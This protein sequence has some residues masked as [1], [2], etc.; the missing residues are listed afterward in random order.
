MILLAY[1]HGL[2]V[3]E[4]VSLRREQVDLRQGLLHVRRRKN[5]MPSTHPLRG[6]ELRALREVLRD[7]PETAYVFVSERKA[8]MTAATFRK[9]VARA[10]TRPGSGC[11][12]TRTCCA[13]PPATN[14]PTTA[15]T[16]APSSITSGTGTSSTPPSILNS[17]PIAS[18]TSGRTETVSA[19]PSG[20]L[21]GIFWGLGLHP[22]DLNYGREIIM[23]AL[24]IDK[25]SGLEND[26]RRQAAFRPRSR[27]HRPAIGRPRWIELADQ[28]ERKDAPAQP[29][30][31]LENNA[32]RTAGDSERRFDQVFRLMKRGTAAGG[33]W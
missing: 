11:Q 23:A 6:P 26:R 25:A 13:T 10:G 4:L 3:S 32:L 18:T 2:R 9:I 33:A 1:R 27:G 24:G 17:L 31:L 28:F 20:A 7:Y 5:G 16:H 21:D 8:P 30:A 15:R 19:E 29:L 12:S 14:S 22:R